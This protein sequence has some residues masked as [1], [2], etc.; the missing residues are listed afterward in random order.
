MGGNLKLVPLTGVTLPL[1]S[2]GGSSLCISLI[3]I[4]LLMRLS[5]EQRRF[6]NA[7]PLSV[8]TATSAYTRAL[9]HMRYLSVSLFVILAI[10]T[11]YWA[12]LSRPRGWAR[13]L[14]PA[15]RPSRIFRR[16]I[17]EGGGK[18]R[19]I[20]LNSVEITSDLGTVIR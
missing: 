11:G 15:S 2:Y 12:I 4:G 8:S 17:R 9:H 18:G 19:L 1:I 14:G 16:S 6:P 7:P 10:G 5:Y 20:H 3:G 13:G